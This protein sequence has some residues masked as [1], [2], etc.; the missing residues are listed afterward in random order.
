MMEFAIVL[1]A[2]VC[3]FVRWFLRIEKTDDSTK[4]KWRLLPRFLWA[5]KTRVGTVSLFLF[6]VYIFYAQYLQYVSDQNDLQQEQ[7]TYQGQLDK[8]QAL[9]ND[10]TAEVGRN[11]DELDVFH[12][13]V[14]FDDSNSV[15][16]L[17][18]NLGNDFMEGNWKLSA[19]YYQLATN[20]SQLLRLHQV[21]TAGMPFYYLDLLKTNQIQQ[22]NLM[23]NQ[24]AIDEFKQN[25]ANMTNDFYK[26][27]LTAIPG[28]CFHSSFWLWANASNLE[29]V[30]GI[31]E[32]FSS[33]SGASREAKSLPGYVSNIEQSVTQLS[34]QALKEEQKVKK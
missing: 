31:L 23:P 8:K 26:A 2:C 7:R 1:I 12:D 15:Q 18:A 20:H 4:S 33:A 19:S 29:Y 34:Q 32:P 24:E 30:R 13:F 9:V 5:E 11:R 28:D 27:S 22:S 21:E 25:L 17:N 10:F 6:G 3:L 14:N 16:T